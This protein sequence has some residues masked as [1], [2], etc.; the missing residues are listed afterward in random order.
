MSPTTLRKS[1]AVLGLGLA[2]LALRPAAALA[3]DALGDVDVALSRWDVTAARRELAEAE[4]GVGKQVKEGII[5][6]Y[7]GRYADAESVLADA[8]ATGSLDGSDSLAEEARHYLALARGAQKA[9]GAAITVTS[10]DGSVTAVFAHEKDAMLAPYLFDAMATARAVLGREL[11]VVPDHAVRFEFLDDP[12]KLAMVTPLTV[13]NIRT[14]G[15]VGVTKHRRVVMITPRV[16][17]HG[18]GWL[19][20]AVHEYVHYLLTL[21]TGNLAPVWL[22]EG[23]AKLYETRWRRDEPEPLDPALAFRLHQAIVRDDLVTLEEMYPSVAMLPSAEL[24]AL[25]YAEVETMLGLLRERR[26]AIGITTLLDRV[27]AGDDA[28]DALATAWGE[29]FDAFHAEWK[30]V[31]KARTAKAKDG[32]IDVPTFG[33]GEAAPAE[34]GDVFSALGGGKA[35]QHARLGALLQERKHLEA[36]AMQYEKARKADPRARKD[37]A[38]SRRLGK[39]YVELERFADA[40]PVLEIAAVD[41]PDDANLAAAQTRALLRSGDRDGA[42]AAAARVLRNNPFVPTVHCDLAEIA[43]APEAIARERALCRR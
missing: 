15:T 2:A 32:K 35:R 17:L 23:L 1:I 41:A 31:T 11:G 34:L 14:T 28:K 13:A 8:V 33:D 16:M 10:P 18:Y 4:D 22:Q 21:R 30:R 6:I 12:V 26:G 25:A 36:A 29:E 3:D 20:T 9:L 43:T 37:P 24:A 42:S 7:E 27:E 39:L 19:D 5:A 38:L 40:A